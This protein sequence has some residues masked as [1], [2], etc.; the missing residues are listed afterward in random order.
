M[1]S[2]ITSIDI[3]VYLGFALLIS[4]CYLFL[5]LTSGIVLKFVLSHVSTK[6]QNSTQNDV[7]PSDQRIRDTGFIV[8]KCENILIPTLILLDAYTALAIIFTAKTIVRA[9]DMKSEN[10]LYFLA[11]TMVNF[12]Y[13]LYIGVL[14]KAIASIYF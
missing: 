2:G 6:K 4:M 9:E 10:T 8:G 12:T 11:G 14:M 13:S 1:I 3:H 5:I 7:I